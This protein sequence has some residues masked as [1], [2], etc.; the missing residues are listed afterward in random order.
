MMTVR[1]LG[2]AALS[3]V[4]GGAAVWALQAGSLTLAPANMTYADLAAV[5]LGAVAALI[6]V[7]GVFMAVL[8]VWGYSQFRVFVE[9]AATTRVSQAM[10]DGELKSLFE[11]RA[12]K[13][14]TEEFESGKL[15]RLLEERVDQIIIRGPQERDR[16]ERAGDDDLNI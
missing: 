7:L 8:A 12:V 13:F 14:M 15:R 3:G 9:G 16:A 1:T 2:V 6:A 10:E 11:A 4:I 5:M